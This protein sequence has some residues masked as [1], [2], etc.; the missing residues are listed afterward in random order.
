MVGAIH[1]WQEQCKILRGLRIIGSACTDCGCIGHTS[2]AVQQ[3][4]SYCRSGCGC[5]L[6]GHRGIGLA[7]IRS[8][9]CE[10]FKYSSFW[11]PL[12]LVG[13]LRGTRS[14]SRLILPHALLQVGEEGVEVSM[15]IAVRAMVTRARCIGRSVCCVGGRRLFTNSPALGRRR[16]SFCRIATF[17]SWAWTGCKAAS[18]VIA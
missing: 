11:C 1:R 8:A 6:P 4:I 16:V 5:S 14:V 13:V 9:T 17:I 3:L 7:G 15:V 2:P 12:P 18:V 10:I